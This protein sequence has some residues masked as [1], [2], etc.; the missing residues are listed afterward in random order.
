MALYLSGQDKQSL[1]A[2]N[3]SLALNPRYRAS[4]LLKA[5]ILES[6]GKPDAAQAIRDEAEFLPEGNW[7]ESVKVR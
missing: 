7:S 4:L 5:E 3:Q 2:V 1:A 6:L